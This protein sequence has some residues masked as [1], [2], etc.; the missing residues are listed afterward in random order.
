MLR[1]QPVNMVAPVENL[2]ITLS[3]WFFTTKIC[4]WTAECHCSPANT[5][6]FYFACFQFWNSTSSISSFTA[7]Q[8]STQLKPIFWRHT[9]SWLH[10]QVSLFQQVPLVLVSNL[11]HL[12][13]RKNSFVHISHQTSLAGI[14][15]W[16]CQIESLPYKHYKAHL[17]ILIWADW[18][19]LFKLKQLL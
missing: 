18:Y 12:H 2:W 4:Q 3:E 8:S 6:K 13:G 7:L 5:N 9:G 17:M 14:W 15:S 19:D 1:F 16:A 10:C 11:T